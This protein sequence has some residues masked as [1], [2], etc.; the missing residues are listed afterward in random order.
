M[1]CNDMTGSSMYQVC[2]ETLACFRKPPPP[3][4]PPPPSNPRPPH[5]GMGG[6]GWGG[7]VKCS[8]MPSSYLTAL[9]HYIE[10]HFMLKKTSTCNR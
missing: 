10:E 2:S 8:S 7:H 4:S 9:T 1:Q 6:V 3:S 5:C